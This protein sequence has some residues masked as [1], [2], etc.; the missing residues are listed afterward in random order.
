MPFIQ[1]SQLAGLIIQGAQGQQG[2]VGAQG[3]QGAT[4]AQGLA[5]AQG[6]QGVIGA[7]GV[8]GATGAQG[9]QG[10]TGAQGDVGA[11]GVQ[12]AT[13]SPGAQGVQ[14]ATGPQGVQGATGSPGAQGVQGATGPQGVQG[15]VGAQGV[16]GSTGPTGAPGAQGVQGTVGAQGSTGPTGTPGAQ[17]VQGATGAQGVQ[18]ATGAQGVQGATGAQGTIGAQGV[19]GATGAQG[20]QGVTGPVAG[21][22]NQVVYKDGSNNAAGSNNLLFNGSNLSLGSISPWNAYQVL[23]IGVGSF[24]SYSPSSD[25]YVV[26][27]A[28]YQ[29]G[30]KYVSSSLPASAFQIANGGFNFYTAASGTA[31]AAVGFTQSMTITSAGLVGIGA[32]L[33]PAVALHVSASVTNTGGIGTEILRVANLRVNTGSSGAAIS[34]VTNEISGSTQYTRAQITGEYDDASN[35][36][37]RLLFATTNT[38]GTLVERMRIDSAGNVKVN[39]GTQYVQLEPG[40]S[41]RGVH[42][43]GGGGDTII[44]AITGISNG[45]QI[46]V[47]SGNA[48][49]YKWHNGGTQSMT[50]ND[51]GNLGIGTTSPSAHARLHIAGAPYAFIALQA[52]NSGGRQYELFTQAS[53]SSFYL[54]DR[55]LDK[56]RLACNSSGFIGIGTTSPTSPFHVAGTDVTGIYKATSTGVAYHIYQND[57][58]VFYVGRDDSGGGAFPKSYCNVLWGSAGVATV[59]ATGNSEKMRLT[60]DGSLLI[61]GTTQPVN[62]YKQVITFS[63]GSG[64]VGGALLINDADGANIYPAVYFRKDGAERGNINVSTGGTQYNSVSDYRLKENVVPMTGALAKVA[65]LKP[66]T[67]KWKENNLNG[68]GFIAHE[69][70]EVVPDCVT[71][72][73]DALD[74]KGNPKYQ[75]VDTSFLVAT[76][77][78]A[79]Q[80]QQALIESLR[81]EFESYKSTHP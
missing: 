71:G 62:T 38:S 27:N 23:Q 54:Y 53:D 78:A 77:T 41:I 8:Q 26:G 20:A 68:Q 10:A 64:G 70:A 37:G 5:G 69:L 9:V 81:T 29:S 47:T 35:I 74:K 17:G 24:A 21:S 65:Q 48:Q 30:W 52:T 45:Y 19:Q 63:G 28:Y 60:S 55:T 56:Y 16:Q 1:Q 7:Q 61:N 67:Y 66:V 3:V 42:S 40:G 11:Q 18:G 13:G 2:S 51:S 49:T 43:N 59:F 72:E 39:S 14:G 73:K 76:L 79:I 75:G 34:F 33:T 50:L 31:D 32:A 22:A 58:G 6:V 36:N 25:T 57:G 12:G 80:E 46:N 15:A 4:G 44:S